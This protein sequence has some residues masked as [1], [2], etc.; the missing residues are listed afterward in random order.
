MI[1]SEEPVHRSVWSRT[2]QEK[3][4]EVLAKASTYHLP[5]E[6]TE[7]PIPHLP[8]VISL[9]DDQTEW[10]ASIGLPHTSEATEAKKIYVVK[11]EK[12]DELSQKYPYLKG[13]QTFHFVFSNEIFV[14]VTSQ[15]SVNEVLNRISHERIHSVTTAQIYNENSKTGL[16][17][18]GFETR[19]DLRNNKNF[20]FSAF[21][22][23]LTELGNIDFL[24]YRRKNGKHD[25]LTG[26]KVGYILLVLLIDFVI[27]K[28]TTSLNTELDKQ[29]THEQVFRIL[30][31]GMTAR[32]KSVFGLMTKYLGAKAV[33][34]LANLQIVDNP[35]YYEK[36]AEE[37]G[38]SKEEY[39]KKG[40]AYSR[41][42]EITLFGG[43]TEIKTVN[44]NA[45]TV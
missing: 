24:D 12:I 3:H 33:K 31:R 25:S 22:E 13:H 43:R 14:G 9:I 6:L 5:K 17:N 40:M 18:K 42:E 4:A 34:N 27:E 39:R 28:L 26:E 45:Q 41:G 35:E 36:M 2:S 8:E 16:L 29:Y 44:K 32:D 15:T 37:F 30:F 1:I 11:K 20:Y 10:F 19:G 23:G 21:Q 38:I 7:N